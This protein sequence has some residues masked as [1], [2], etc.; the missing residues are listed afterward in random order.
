MA[1]HNNQ[2]A[3]S[4]LNRYV[5]LKGETDSKRIYDNPYYLKE[6]QQVKSAPASDSTCFF[7]ITPHCPD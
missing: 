4:D 1:L 6:F 7:L 2:A 3:E 5:T